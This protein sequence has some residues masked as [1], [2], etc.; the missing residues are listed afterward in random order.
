MNIRT[1]RKVVSIVTCIAFCLISYCQRPDSLKIR[2]VDSLLNGSMKSMSI[3]GLSISVLKKGKVIYKKAFGYS[4]IEL[5]SPSTIQSNYLIGS[6][7]KTFTAVAAMLL[8]EQEKFKLD[9]DIGTYLPDLPSHWKPVTIR[10]LLNHTSGITT[11]LE[12][13]DSFCKFNYTIENYTHRN[14]IEETACLPLRFAPGSKFEYSGRNYFLIG[15][16]IEKLAGKPYEEFLRENIFLPLV[17]DKTSMINYEKLISNRADGYNLDN[18]IFINS[19]QMNP[20]I[21]FSD[22]GLVSTIEDLE[23]WMVGL[24][25]GNVL[26]QATLDMMWSNPVLSDGKT[27]PYGIGFG[28]SP[29]NGQRRVGHTG[30]I[31]GYSSCITHFIDSDVIVILLSNTYHENYN[32]GLLGNRVAELFGK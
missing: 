8:W 13:P 5:K 7:T 30:G 17:M 21:E 32:V 31:P 6:V 2:A 20:V 4:N 15:M 26:K 12:K 23:K 18:G 24:K 9:D 14:V 25:S 3:P 1:F 10:Q 29:Y 27:A 16:L 22:G 28:L 11:N 19:Q